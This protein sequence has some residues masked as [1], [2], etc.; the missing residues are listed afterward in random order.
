MGAIWRKLQRSLASRERTKGTRISARAAQPPEPA[1]AEAALH[2]FD[3]RHGVDTGG[4]IR[5]E[6][7]HSGSRHDVFNAG[8]YGMSPSR[9]YWI[10][11]QWIADSTH[12]KIVDYS[13]I[14]LGCGKGRAV[15]MASEFTFRQIIGVELH[16][17]LTRIAN[18]NLD[19]WKA[20]HSSCPI[21]IVCHDATEFIFPQGPC[22]LYL[23][24][25]FAGEAINRL[26][27]RLETQ[28]ADRRGLLD[29][30]YFNPELGHLFDA[31]RGFELLWTGTV[32]M[33]QED[34][35][36]DSLASPEDLCSVFRWSGAVRS[37]AFDR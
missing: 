13:F 7:L 21:E 18:D 4:L 11:Q 34:T 25:P 1:D 27:Q 19:R 28:F 2:P 10:L 30:I 37:A 15:M 5:G 12:P 3:Q 29:I 16:P 17:G 24:N 32:P 22:L 26:I 6:E 20:N 36:A 31:R 35:A 9:F 33:S 23:F 14:D 8:Y